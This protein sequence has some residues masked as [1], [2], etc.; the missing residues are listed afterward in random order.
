MSVPKVERLVVVVAMLAMGF[1]STAVARPH[2]RVQ[3]TQSLEVD[4]SALPGPVLTGATDSAEFRIAYFDDESGSAEI[5]FQCSGNAQIESCQAPND[6]FMDDG[7]T[8]FVWV[9]FTASDT[10]GSAQ[11]EL[12]ANWPGG[13]G[14]GD[15]DWA[16]FTV[17][18]SVE[19]IATGVPGSVLQYAED[20]SASFDIV[21]KTASGDS[22]SFA[23][24]WA[25]GSCSPPAPNFVGATDTSTVT[26]H[27]STGPITGSY[28][29]TL[30][31]TSST[32]QASDTESVVVGAFMTVTATAIEDPVY[33]DNLATDTAYFF[34]RFP[35]QTGATFDL[36]WTC[37]GELEDCPSPSDTTVGDEGLAVP[38]SY[39]SGPNGDTSAITLTV[40]H[41]DNA[42]ITASATL[43]VIVTSGILFTVDDANPG[44]ELNRGDCLNVSAGAISIV[45]DDV[46]Y[47]Y[48]FMPVMRMNTP[49]QVGLIFNGGIARPGGVV[50]ANFVLPAGETEPDSIRFNLDI[51]GT[52][53]GTWTYA[54]DLYEPGVKTRV[55]RPWSWVTPYGTQ[56]RHY[57]YTMTPFYGASHGT[58]VIATGHLIDLDHRFTF[59]V[60]WW[61]AGYE[62]LAPV[63]DSILG[64]VLIWTGGDASARAYIEEGADTF[65]GWTRGRPD[66][67]LVNQ[68]STYTRRLLG[69]GAVHFDALGVHQTTEDA[70]GN[71]T[72]F[73]YGIYPFPVAIRTAT[74]SGTDTIYKLE[75]DSH[76]VDLLVRDEDGGWNEYRLNMAACEGA[77]RQIT[78]I[79]APDSTVIEFAWQG[80]EGSPSC[81][82]ELAEVE[83][84]TDVLTSM[85]YNS[86][87]AR[88]VHVST[89]DDTIFIDY[90][91]ART[92]G[93][94]TWSGHVYKPRPA[95]AVSAYVNGPLETYGD[96]TRFFTTAWGAV[97]G[98]RDAYG[99]ETWID[100]DNDSFPAL[101]TRVRH[102]NGWELRAAY[103]PDG[104]LDHT[105]NSATGGVTAYA[106]NE[107]YARPDTIVSPEGVT[108][109]LTYTASGDL[110]TQ[111]VLG[112][113]TTTFTYD[114]LGLV[115]RV[116]DPLDNRDTLTY[117]DFGNLASVETALGLTTTYERDD[118]GRQTQ[119]SRPIDGGDDRLTSYV[120]DVMGRVTVEETTNE[121]DDL[122]ARVHTTYDTIGRRIRVQAF[123]DTTTAAQDSMSTGLQEWTYDDLNRVVK[124]RSGPKTDSLWYDRAGNLREVFTNRDNEI[125]M[126]YDLLGRLSKRWTSAVT[127][128]SQT[129]A[130]D[131]LPYYSSGLTIA[132]DTVTYSYDVLGHPLTIDNRYAQITRT[133]TLDGLITTDQQALKNYGS[134]SFGTHVYDLAY[135]YDRDRRRVGL[136]HPT[137][138][139]PG[140]DLTTWTF[141]DV[142]RVETITGPLGD[143]YGYAYDDANRIERRT[144]PAAG[145]SGGTQWT[146]DDGDRLASHRIV[147]GTD[148]IMTATMTRNDD[149][150][151]ASVG[152][153]TSGSMTYTGL[154]AVG[155][156]DNLAWQGAS[157]YEAFV[158]DPFGS[159]LR[160]VSR[161]GIADSTAY[162]N[163]VDAYGRVF[164]TQEVWASH[165]GWNE[166]GTW[167]GSTATYTSDPAGNRSWT[168]SDTYTWI[169]GTETA[170]NVTATKQFTFREEAKSFYS[171]DEQLMVHQVNRDSID[172]T[173]SP[174]VTEG[175]W[176]TYEEYWYDG[177]S[178]RVLKRS[179]EEGG[180]CEIWTRCHSAIERYVWDGSQIVWELRQDGAGDTKLPSGFG[181]GQEGRIGYVHGGDVDAPLA[182]IRNDTAIVLH[183]NWRGLYAFSTDTA[184]DQTTCTPIPSGGCVGIQ[185]PG[186]NSLAFL[187][188]AS[189]DT[190][191]WYGS[192]VMDQQDATGLS[193]RRNRY[194]DPASG[195]FTQQDP[196]GIAGG[197]NLYGY[198]NGDP[199]NF[200]D[201]FG[202]CPDGPVPCPPPGT[203]TLL[204][205]A[206]GFAL[207]GGFGGGA[208]GL[209]GGL[210]GSLGG[211]AAPATVP[212]SAT[213]GATIGATQ[214]AV[215]GA[216][217]G[218]VIGGA[219]DATIV[220]A[221]GESAQIGAAISSVMGKVLNTEENRRDVGDYCESCKANGVRGTANNRGDFTFQELKERV[222]E[223]FGIR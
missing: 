204:G 170:P 203:F 120:Y 162:E 38:V 196:I 51:D 127:Y 48:P 56:L 185:W 107:Q 147:I 135:H 108:T 222:R 169:W 36:A 126:E 163:A 77:E 15:T 211:L 45:C 40:T 47:V 69:G 137:W 78:S 187:Q 165:E 62:R 157:T 16:F 94:N 33:S 125:G 28:D 131:S 202:L 72:H 101:P 182:M 171:A 21:N 55:S 180:H 205:T 7:D 141:D 113:G 149:G 75:N 198:A 140:T 34:V 179:R 117:D 181:S 189:R 65:V 192:L 183:Q 174:D 188:N 115:I 191:T 9:T 66:T 67:V 53:Q 139:S 138:L 83:G 63:T 39:T 142:G 133:Y 168:V 158:M 123:G 213:A 136:T 201:P 190:M 200:S 178:R 220:F 18:S 99:S 146:Y 128:E 25:G 160:S 26:V 64:H 173:A 80:A 91:A 24:S 150:T 112:S 88:G 109:V 43:D 130:L 105:V 151:V 93:S 193:Y 124:S 175:K 81:G 207:G 214:G 44:L 184:G 2:D 37:G 208:G 96:S 4:P 110:Q 3:M 164:S 22:M 23:C 13:G 156:S 209:V 145:A 223:F 177:L 119:V 166:P 114:T 76:G 20:D 102:P 212:A 210:A 82:Y 152:G 84:V 32:S 148:T 186:G 104:L 87:S 144:F 49:R 194:Y 97:R 29:L 74:P 161:V 95:G 54:D 17:S 52:E 73:D 57:V 41:S 1:T 106:W 60:G 5:N 216:A 46:Q 121:V 71:E 90:E 167:Q 11:L 30:T 31:A 206:A 153:N 134:S 70:N 27:F 116:V 103:R 217:I 79:V 155:E 12:A 50:G 98:T 35:G 197:L 100:R 92:I 85:S 14:Q 129:G 68:D 195:Q 58:D 159:Q 8:A 86:G 176:G 89:A 221:K 59:G 132:A 215:V 6:V 218:G 199:I 154:G 122:W 19:V 42:A 219:I 172:H 10:T 143:S 61:L 111:Q 118:L